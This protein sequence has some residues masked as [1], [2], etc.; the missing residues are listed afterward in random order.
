LNISGSVQA[1]TIDQLNKTFDE[2][3]IKFDKVSHLILNFESIKKEITEAF[4][5]KFNKDSL[6]K[7]E[8]STTNFNVYPYLKNN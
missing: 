6:I 7:L 5:Y 1:A 8:I 3:H 2:Q 4:I